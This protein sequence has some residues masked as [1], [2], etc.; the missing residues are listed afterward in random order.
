MIT[1][2]EAVIYVFLIVGVAIGLYKYMDFDDTPEV[3]RD[4]WHGESD[5]N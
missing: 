3:P 1:P 4:L 5:E 2:L